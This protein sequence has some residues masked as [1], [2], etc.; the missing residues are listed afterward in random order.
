MSLPTRMLLKTID[1]IYRHID[2]TNL[3]NILYTIIVRQTGV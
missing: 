1:Y 2:Y 3:K